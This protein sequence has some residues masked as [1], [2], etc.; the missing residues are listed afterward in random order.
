M[1]AAQYNKFGEASQ[2][3]EL[4]DCPIPAAG[5]GEVRIMVKASGV[6]PSD[7]KVRS[8]HIPSPWAFPRIPHSDGAGIIDAV[9]EG[10]DPARVGDRV[11]IFNAAWGRT[12]GTAAE[13]VVVPENFTAPLPHG[14]PFDIGA[15]LGIPASTALHALTLNGDL[16]GKSVL[17]A[18]GAGAVGHYAVQFARQLGAERI[19]A[20]VSSP[21]KAKIA[22]LSGADR[23]INY[24]EED[25]LKAI[26]DATDGAGAD[27]IVEVDLAA[28]IDLDVAALAKGGRVVAYGS[29]EREFKMPFSKSILKNIGFDFFILY[30]LPEARR[31]EISQGVN[32]LIAQGNVTHN[33][34][35]VLPLVSIASA[36]ALVESG[37]AVGNVVLSI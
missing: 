5:V 10:V 8:G 11:W 33:I 37:K 31:Q 1:R 15:C 30:H 35:E 7:V 12:T 16:Q 14:T 23:T 29:S 4:V 9:G 22:Q 26:L 2:V 27:L 36:H 21:E 34:A 20:T 13:Y 6:N 25:A 19:L 28:N 24:R 3:L 32:D 18:G 17:I